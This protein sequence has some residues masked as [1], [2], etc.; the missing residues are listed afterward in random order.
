MIYEPSQGFVN[1]VRRGIHKQPLC[2]DKDDFCC[3]AGRCVVSR[4]LSL[5]SPDLGGNLLGLGNR[6]VYELL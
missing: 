6:T 5:Y 2:D 1:L 4:M 3:F